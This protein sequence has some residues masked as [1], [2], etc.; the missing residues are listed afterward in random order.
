MFVGVEWGVDGSYVSVGGEDVGDNQ[1]NI[2]QSSK[3]P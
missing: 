3:E 2:G 1:A